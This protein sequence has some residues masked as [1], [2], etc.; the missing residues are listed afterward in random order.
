MWSGSRVRIAGGRLLDLK[1]SV[2]VADA[3]SFLYLPLFVG[4]LNVKW[5]RNSLFSERSGATPSI[6]VG[7]LRLTWRK[8]RSFPASRAP[9]AGSGLD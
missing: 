6:V 8:R 1:R 2:R 4:Q 5:K 3:P 7:P 9:R